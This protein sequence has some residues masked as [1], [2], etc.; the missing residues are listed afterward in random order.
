MTPAKLI[1]E[2][3][4]SLYPLANQDRAR[5]MSAYLLNQ[6]EFLGL[7]APIR[8]TV[9]KDLIKSRFEHVN[10]LLVVAATLWSK[11]EREFRYTAIDLLKQHSS[12]LNSENLPDLC[13][14]LLRDSWWETVDGLSSVISSVMLAEHKRQVQ[15]SCVMDE[16][17]THKDKWVRRAAMLHQLGW[18]METNSIRLTQYALT[19]ADEK[20]FFI[21]KAIGWALRDYAR[22]NPGFVR[23]FVNE[24]KYFLSPLTMREA[25]KHLRNLS[26]G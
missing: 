5:A 12:M 2:I 7:P 11:K 10:D 19:L 3:E 18:R 13:D 17:L 21:R 9:V 22:W 24:N 14:L 25:S 6:F 8:R 20:E 15:V 1:T 23:Q 26:Q 16:W 4:N